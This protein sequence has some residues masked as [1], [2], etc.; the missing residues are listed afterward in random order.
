[1][2]FLEWFWKKWYI[3]LACVVIG[4]MLMQF[5]GDLFFAPLASGST[6][7][8]FIAGVSVSYVIYKAS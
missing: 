7:F 8:G 2:S 3:S 4:A 6:L 5:I 1:M